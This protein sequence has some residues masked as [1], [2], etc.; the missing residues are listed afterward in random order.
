M[1][2]KHLLTPLLLATVLGCAPDIDTDKFQNFQ[3][4]GEWSIPLLNSRVSLEDILVEDTLFTVDPDGALRLIYE[5]DSLI[6]FSIDDFANVPSQD[7]IVTTVPMD[8]PSFSVSSSLGTI[9]GAEFKTLRI[10]EGELNFEVTNALSATVELLVVI[11]NATINGSTFQVSLVAPVGTSQQTVSVAGLEMDLSDG[12]TT[13]NYI[14]FDIQVVNNGGAPAGSTVDLS[15]TYQDLLFGRAVGYFGQRSINVPT[16]NF[17]LG[18]QAFENFLDGLYLD[19]PTID[20]IVSTNVGLPLQLDLDMDGINTSGDLEPLG[21][22]SIQISGPSVIGDYDTTVVRIDKNTSNIV[23]FIANVP[24]T[25]LYSGSGIMNPQGQTGTD[26]FVTADGEMQ[27]GLRL[28]LPLALRTQNLVFE[29]LIE[30][31]DFGGMEEATDPI[32]K[33]ILKFHVENEFPLDADLK[34]RF[35]DDNNAA[36]DSV[37]LDLFDAAPVD[38]NGR[39]TGYQITVEEET[40]TGAKIERL[41]RSKKLEL[42][43]TMN[44]TN[45]GN[46]TVVLYDDYDIRVKLGV[47][48]KLQYD[49]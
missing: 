27:L 34:L 40:I 35:L 43:V 39:S 29:Q 41:I 11:N 20:L 45:N 4:R 22:N 36:T 37:S 2:T 8:V 28:D 30:D 31:I 14:S 33:L 49:L 3:Y 32:E 46:T 10:R 17:E 1:K 12:G 26:N 23:D 9:G 42:I 47:Q 18:V 38:A 7:P 16:G 21:L 6:G 5:S 48:A 24:N 13:T 44:T 19:D 25:I 15:M